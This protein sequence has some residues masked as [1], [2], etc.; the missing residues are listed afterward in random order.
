[1][2][3]SDDGT[4]IQTFDNFSSPK[5][6]CVSPDGQQL[7][8]IDFTGFHVLRI[9]DGTKTLAIEYGL[10]YD[11]IGRPADVCTDGQ[12]LFFADGNR[13]KVFRVDDKTYVRSIGGGDKLTGFTMATSVCLSPTNDHIF[14]AEDGYGRVQVFRIDG[15]HVLTIGGGGSAIDH[16]GRIGRSG[17]EPGQFAVPMGVCVSPDGHE[18]FVADTRNSRVQ[19]FLI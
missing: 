8:V 15:T 3:R 12:H 10:G 4:H 6:L 5:R 17:S 11:R 7:F 2:L 9:E 18:L 16:F 1:M 19:I 13:V 14:V